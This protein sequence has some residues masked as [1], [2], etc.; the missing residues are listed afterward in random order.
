MAIVTRS[1]PLDLLVQGIDDG[2]VLAPAFALGD[3]AHV[4]GVVDQNQAAG[5]D[6][7]ETVLVVNVVARLVGIDEGEIVVPV[8]AFSAERRKALPGVSQTQ[9]DPPGEPRL[10]PVALRDPRIVRVDVERRDPAVRTH[11]LRDHEGAVAGEDTDLQRAPG[12]DQLH[13][14]RHQR[15]LL[16][17]NLHQ[18]HLVA[19]GFLA[20]AAHD[21]A[22]AHAV[23]EK[24]IV[25]RLGERGGSG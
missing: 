11:C 9:F 18:P 8:E 6:Q 17:R 19:R 5:A 16:R 20:Q 2:G 7:S 1:S 12:P 22:L 3:L 14:Q 25:Q 24:I 15:A 13:Q 23:G 4:E 21:R 10:R